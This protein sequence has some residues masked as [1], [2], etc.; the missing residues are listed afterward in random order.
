MN[1]DSWM[2]T[3]PSTRQNSV[4]RLKATRQ[5]FRGNAITLRLHWEAQNLAFVVHRTPRPSDVQPQSFMYSFG[6]VGS[7]CY[8]ND[9]SFVAS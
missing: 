9:Q 3:R 7:T 1:T 6:L 8:M 4:L 2:E 5:S